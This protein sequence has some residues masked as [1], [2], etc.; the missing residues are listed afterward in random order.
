MPDLARV[1]RVVKRNGPRSNSN[2][3]KYT[4]SGEYVPA[5]RPVTPLGVNSE[6]KFSRATLNAPEGAEAFPSP[7][8]RSWTAPA[9]T[10]GVFLPLKKS[11]YAE[12]SLVRA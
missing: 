3:L 5:N 10:S 6:I 9:R 8:Q 7:C 12:R 1:A 2:P 4:F 11:R